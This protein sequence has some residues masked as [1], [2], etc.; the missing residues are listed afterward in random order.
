MSR[1]RDPERTRHEILK[2]AFDE[3]YANGFRATSIDDIVAKAGVTK[4][5][6]FHYFPTKNDV[7]YAIADEVLGRMMMDRWIRPLA[8]YRNPVQGM[9]VRFKKLMEATS[10]EVLALGCP[11]NN[12][13]QEMSPIDPIFREKLRAVMMLSINETE[14]YLRKAQKDGFLRPGVDPRMAAEFLVMCQEGSAALV[15][16]LKDRRVYTSLYD[17]YRRFL[18]SISTSRPAQK[19]S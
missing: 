15:K 16:N 6:F 3:T 17:G 14:K 18:E 5:A 2:A 10:D 7:G 19:S 11:L 12:L 13:T 8:A 1:P 4:G 9:I